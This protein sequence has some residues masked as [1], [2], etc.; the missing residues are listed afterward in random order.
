MIFWKRKLRK[1]KNLWYPQSIL[2]GK[3]ADTQE[4]AERIANSCT[5]TPSDVHAVIRALPEVMAELMAESRSVH[6]D[7]LGCFFYSIQAKGT[8]VATEAE[9]SSSQITSVR[10]QFLPSRKRQGT[11]ITR[12]LVGGVSFAEWLGKDTSTD[13]SGSS[14]GSDTDSGTG[15]NGSSGTDNEYPME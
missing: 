13:T 9:V 12:S 6:L 11:V 4:V 1:L 14:G 7:G 15:D 5:L 3:P 2:V 8:G 10:V